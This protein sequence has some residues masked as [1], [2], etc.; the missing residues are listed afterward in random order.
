[1]QVKK[2]GKTFCLF[3]AALT[4]L[5]AARAELEARLELDPQLLRLGESASLTLSISGVRNPPRPNFPDIDGLQIRPAG[6]STNFSGVNLKM[7]LTTSFNYVVTPE[8]TGDFVIGPYTY[9][10]GGESAELA[11]VE[12]KVIPPTGGGQVERAQQTLSDLLYARI[13]IPQERIYS[14][15][16]FQ[17]VLKIFAREGLNLTGNFEPYGFPSSRLELGQFSSLGRTRVE[18]DGEL[19]TVYQFVA[20]ARASASGEFSLQPGLR[21]A[22]RTESGVERR[23]DP[24][25]GSFFDSF[26]DRARVEQVDV[27]VEPLALEVLPIPSE[28]R[29]ASYSGAV[30]EFDFSVQVKPQ[31]VDAGDPVTITMTVAGSGNIDNVVAP[32]LELGDEFKS[33]EARL[34][35]DDANGGARKVFEQV[36]IPRSEQVEQLPAIEFSYFSPQEGAYKTVERGPFPLKVNP[37]ERE[38]LQ[39]SADPGELP[40][41]DPQVLGS[42]IV[43]LK[44]PPAGRVAPGIFGPASSLYFWIANL[45]PVLA[46]TVLY[47]GRRRRE[48][49]QGNVAVARRQNAPRAARAALARAERALTENER[50]AFFDSVWSAAAD[51]FGNRL[52]LAPGETG[53]DEMLDFARRAG[54]DDASVAKLADTMRRCELERFAARPDGDADWSEEARAVLADLRAIFKKCESLKLKRGSAGL[55]TLFATGAALLLASIV[56]TWAARQDKPAPGRS[57]A[58]AAEAYDAGDLAA[59]LQEY[60]DLL[61]AGEGS[62]QL[63]YNIGNT[64]FRMGRLPAAI[65]NY[66]RA[67]Y[68]AP[69]D[70][71]IAANMELAIRDSGA[72][73]DDRHPLLNLAL[74][75]SAREWLWAAVACYWILAALLAAAIFSRRYRPVLLKAAPA[76]AL[77]L[78]LSLAGLYC[79][80][81]LVS[82]NESVVIGD[83]QQARFAPI[84]D[85][86]VHFALPA[87]SLVAVSDQA[88]G[89]AQVE[90][91]GK[92]GWV[93]KEALEPV[94]SPRR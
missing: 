1:M 47:A 94:L 73:V 68:Y 76:P 84:A 37:S 81:G 83:D 85:A 82:E 2:F 18:I 80:H 41:S 8:R 59:A 67:W 14:Q 30:G 11:P 79:W 93:P 7:K 44:D 55:R 29:P 21:A 71:D 42:D 39:V 62:P 17:I 20:P 34:I 15:Q 72:L 54:L 60:N 6:Q 58:R 10:A 25:G 33:Y 24:F 46:L 65:L 56:F 90:L 53:T 89:W 26:F 28:G 16:S 66:R 49:L 27:P 70:P 4:C 22:L 91:D 48:Y 75:L 50:A 32:A 63:Y 43:Y 52:N 77:L 12:F 51:Y 78:A 57:F 38:L 40:R 19:Y 92:R 5:S 61:Q 64:L 3:L 9:Q 36:V 87:G 35:S 13:E 45:L 31:E 86:T 23:S 69:R 74:Q 88:S